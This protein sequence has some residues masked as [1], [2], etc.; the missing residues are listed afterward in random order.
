MFLQ[1]HL[2][3]LQ[4][5]TSIHICHFRLEAMDSR[6]ALA[7][8]HRVDGSKLFINV[9]VTIGMVQQIS[10]KKNIE[11]VEKET[12]LEKTAQEM[13]KAEEEKEADEIKKAK[14]VQRVKEAK[15][16]KE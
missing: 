5:V 3:I 13:K 11:N 14:E 1:F 12:T 9:A 2:A 8:L 7:V 10:R 6:R 15:Q 16:V 4:A